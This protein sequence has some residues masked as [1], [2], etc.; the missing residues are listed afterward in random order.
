MSHAEYASAHSEQVD[1]VLAVILAIIDPFDR[2]WVAQRLAPCRKLTPWRRQF[3]AALVSSHSSASSFIQVRVSSTSFKD[4][5]WLGRPD[6]LPQKHF[7]QPASIFPEHPS[8]C[9][10]VA[11]RLGAEGNEIHEA[12]RVFGNP[13]ERTGAQRI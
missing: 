4:P 12:R 2:E 6:G 10:L 7:P 3:S 9:R 5:V 8:P 13:R 1:T 11:R